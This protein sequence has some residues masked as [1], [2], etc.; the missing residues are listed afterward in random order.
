MGARDAASSDGRWSAAALLLA[1]GALA[2][3]LGG[4]DGGQ[5]VDGQALFAANCAV[6]HGP[7]GEGG[8]GAPA[9]TEPAYLPDQLSDA[10]VA[11][12]IRNGVDDVPDGY[13]PMPA[14]SRFDDEQLAALVEVVRDLQDS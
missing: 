3:V 8:E 11:A 9:L 10:E 5:E 2:V 14:F 13:G 1:T 6:C 4:C 12:A 7:A